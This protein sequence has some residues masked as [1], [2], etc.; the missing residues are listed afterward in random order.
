MRQ[1]GPYQVVRELG[2]G[3]MGVVYEVR[4]P[5][6]DRRLA[7]KLILTAQVGDPEALLR[8]GREAEAMARVT[9]ANVVKIHQLAQAPEGP[10]LVT[11]LVEG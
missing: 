2:R 4:D 10:Y 9:H 11:E 7:L 8:F 1:I 3:G 6:L 5:A